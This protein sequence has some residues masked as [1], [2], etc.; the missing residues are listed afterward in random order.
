MVQTS[1]S[2][3]PIDLLAGKQLRLKRELMGL[4]QTAL[5]EKIGVSRIK[6]GQY[7]SGQRSIPA[8]QLFQLSQVFKVNI[9]FFFNPDP[10]SVKQN[11][12]YEPILNKEVINLIRDFQNLDNPDVRKA[13]ASIMERTVEI[14]AKQES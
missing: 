6:I 8:S 9:A 4:S 12:P 14:T 5:G 2:I 10:H 7:E 11:P 3:D 13:F 1:Q